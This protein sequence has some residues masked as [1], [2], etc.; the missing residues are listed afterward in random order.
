MNP[1]R[2]PETEPPP[3]RAL[4]LGQV[5]C[6]VIGGILLLAEFSELCDEASRILLAAVLSGDTGARLRI[7]RERVC[8]LARSCKHASWQVQQS[9]ADSDN[10]CIVDELLSFWGA[11]DRQLFAD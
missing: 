11:G 8:R 1:Y 7:D 6:V 3:S 10:R 4:T 9:P 5:A 2:Q